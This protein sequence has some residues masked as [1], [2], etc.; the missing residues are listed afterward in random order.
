MVIKETRK[1][2]ANNLRSVTAVGRK[3]MAILFVVESPASIHLY[4]MVLIILAPLMLS[5]GAAQLLVSLPI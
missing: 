5:L 3:G 1:G 4:L 2:R